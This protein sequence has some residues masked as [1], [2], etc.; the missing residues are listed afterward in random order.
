P[1]RRSSDLRPAPLRGPHRPRLPPLGIGLGAG[2]ATVKPGVDFGA[3]QGPS[4][5][6]AKCV[7]SV[8][9]LCRVIFPYAGGPQSATGLAMSDSSPSPGVGQERQIK[10]IGFVAFIETPTCVYTGRHT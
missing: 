10:S 6:V 1:A 4:R 5:I 2:A 9:G 3:E 8:T 7:L